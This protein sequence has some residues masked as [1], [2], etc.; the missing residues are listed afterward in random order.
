MDQL[1]IREL[2]NRLNHTTAVNFGENLPEFSSREI[3]LIK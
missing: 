3:D 1:N 2:V